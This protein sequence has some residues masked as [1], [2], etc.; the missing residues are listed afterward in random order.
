AIDRL[1]EHAPAGAAEEPPVRRGAVSTQVT[2]Q[3]PHQY[4]RDGDDADSAVG[5][6]LEAA[7]F[8][9]PAGASP[10]GAGARAGR[11]EDDRPTAVRRED[12]VLAAHGDGFLRAQR[13]VVQAAEERGKFRP[14]TRDLGQDLPD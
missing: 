5:P 2:A 8:V 3:C 13:R 12:E 14:D 7:C 6:V 10:G 11:G 9:W 4:R 1:A